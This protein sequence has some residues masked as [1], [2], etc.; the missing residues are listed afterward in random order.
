[1]LIHAIAE[2]LNSTKQRRWVQLPL[3]AGRLRARLYELGAVVNEA[4]S[5][6][7][8]ALEVRLAEERRRQLWRSHGLN[9][10]DEAET[11]AEAEPLPA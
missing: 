1:L 9:P 7:G 8:Y 3:S 4:Q 6:D 2:C 5:D 10:G 11:G